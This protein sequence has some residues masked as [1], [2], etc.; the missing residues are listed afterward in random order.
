MTVKDLAYCAQQHLHTNTGSSFKRAHIYE[1]LVSSFGF[2]SYAA[3][4]VDT[5]FTELHSSDTTV[6]PLSALIKRR[7]IELGYGPDTA[8]IASAKL[9]SYLAE[10]QIGIA[11]ISSLINQLRGESPGDDEDQDEDQEHLFCFPDANGCGPILLDGLETA[12]SKGSAKANYALALIHAPAFDDDGHPD[13]GNSYWHSQQEQGRI[14][15]GVEKEWADAYETHVV[16][17]EKYTRHLREAGRLGNQLALFELAERFDDPS[18][19]E[20]LSDAVDVDPAE[21]A[22]IAERMDRSAD[23]KHWLTVAAESGDTEAM[24][25]LIEDYDQDDL[26]RCWTWAY[27]S[28]LLGTDLTRDA[29]YAINEA[30]SE[31]DDDIGGPAY[32]AGHDGIDLEPLTA[33]QDA[34]AKDAAQNLFAEIERKTR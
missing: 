1:L 24:L 28:Q 26:L 12:A 18:I 33:Q 2:N 19:F 25:Q 21:V 13:G 23:A 10:S 3:F 29:H 32:V 22:S 9:Q 31:Y 11:S 17:T 6:V 30:G 8:T 7:C 34:K 14:L 27:L 15:T 20:Q 16:R 4:G 5:V